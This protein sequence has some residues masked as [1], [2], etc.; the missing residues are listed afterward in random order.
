ML[1]ELWF[2]LIAVLW[3]GFVLLEGFDFG[4]GTL[5]PVLAGDEQERR[6]VLRTFG[7]VWDGNEVWLLVA[8]GATFAA[9]PHWYATVFSGFYVP[10]A[11]LLLGLILRAVC[12]EYRHKVESDRERAWLDRGVVVGSLLPSVLL[13]VALANWV[14]GVRMDDG[15][16]MT[17]SFWDLVSPYAL[18]G[19]LATLL[20]FTFHGSL[21]V[22]L[23]TTGELRARA[24]RV[25]GR[26]GPVFVLVAAGWLG[27]SLQLRGT[28]LAAVLAAAAALGAVVAVLAA[29]AGREGWAFAG[30]SLTSVLLPP[31]VF[32]CLWPYVL[33]GR[34][35]SPGLT[36][37]TAASSPYTLKVMTVVALAV[38]PVVIGYQAWTYWVFRQRITRPPVT[39]VDVSGPD[40]PSVPQQPGPRTP[41]SS[42]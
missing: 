22:A 28:V 34:D 23:R 8:G 18:L 19:G 25:A 29:R 35:G 14:R 26:L 6:I 9:F 4:V 30:T 36:I 38:T 42:P 17:D 31:F 2:V 37:D 1:P 24:L 3:A 33:P 21:F 20:L 10:L 27:W 7:P 12:V 39:A 13:G 15:W 16:N 41:A 11:L 5:L 40:G 32:A